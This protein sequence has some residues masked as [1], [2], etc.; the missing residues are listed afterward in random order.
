MEPQGRMLQGG[1]ERA[2]GLGCGGGSGGGCKRGDVGPAVCSAV[3]GKGRES[4]C[5]GRSK[6]CARGWMKGGSDGLKWRGEGAGGGEV[7]GEVKGSE[8]M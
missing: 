7:G 3:G 8:G 4:Q 1:N 2:G 6:A 5:A